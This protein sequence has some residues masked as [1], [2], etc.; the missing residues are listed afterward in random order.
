VWW[1]QRYGDPVLHLGAQQ[2][3]SSVQNDAHR[4]KELDAENQMLRI[5]NLRLSARLLELGQEIKQ[6]NSLWEADPTLKEP[7]T[8]LPDDDGSDG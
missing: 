3:M 4:L 8:L 5:E 6:L 7:R 2:L 1:D